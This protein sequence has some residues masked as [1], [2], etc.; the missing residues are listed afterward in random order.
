[1]VVKQM[2]KKLIWSL[3]Y[4]I[5]KRHVGPTK[6]DDLNIYHRNYSRDSI[7]TVVSLALCNVR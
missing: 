1:M 6:S 5:H 2:I 4:D 3:G 7:V